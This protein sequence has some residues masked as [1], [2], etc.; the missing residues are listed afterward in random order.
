MSLVERESHGAVAVIRMNRPEKLNAMSLPL[1]TELAAAWRDFQET[2]SQKIAILTG[3]GKAFCAGEDLVESS[4]RGTPG[5]APDLPFDPFFND[6]KGPAEHLPK[7]TIAAVNGWAM[8][9]GFIMAWMCDFRV[10]ARSA[11]FEISEA[12]HWLL[13]AYKFGFT[14]S[15]PWTIAT[16][17]ALGFRMSA[18]RAYEVGF[19]NRLVDD[20][21][22]LACSLEMC[23]HMLSIP[24]ASLKNTLDV[25]RRLR[26]AISTEMEAY[27]SELRSR[28]NI[29][30]VME[31]RK[32]F[33]EKRKPVFKGF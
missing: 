8:G 26:P 24:P 18:E 28:G 23:D 19:A 13:G 14:D 17:L 1:L 30:D 9:G 29:D 32:A 6:A 3:T 16:E 25:A 21:Q 11:V 4:Q 15:L 7:P 2:P 27:G 33:S 20:D 5:L 31:A 12:R 10:A 22:L